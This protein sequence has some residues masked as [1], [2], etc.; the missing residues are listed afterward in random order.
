MCFTNNGKNTSV[1]IATKAILVY[2]GLDRYKGK[3][4]SPYYSEFQWKEK[5]KVQEADFD[6]YPGYFAFYGFH[7]CKTAK[8][9]KLHGNRAYAFIIPKGALYFEN[10]D[11]YIS[12]KIYLRSAKP[13]DARIKSPKL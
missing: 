2:K 8:N 11:Q 1:Q 13:I 5:K 3:L 12:N 4:V 7:S 10:D 9:A 6:S